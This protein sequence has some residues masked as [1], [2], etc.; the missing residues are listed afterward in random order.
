MTD[1]EKRMFKTLM[2]VYKDIDKACRIMSN[3]FGKNEEY[4]KEKVSEAE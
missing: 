4:F 1:E 2:N 3:I